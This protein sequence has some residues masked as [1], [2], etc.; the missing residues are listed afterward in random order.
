MVSATPISPKDGFSPD[1]E[2][3]QQHAHLTRLCGGVALPL[4]LL[5]QRAGAATANAGGIYHAQAS[6]SFSPPLMREKLPACG[7]EQRPIGLER[8]VGSGEAPGFPGRGS[9]R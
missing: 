3:M 6:V 2:R 8:E 7:T 5:T 4:A 1:H 9:G